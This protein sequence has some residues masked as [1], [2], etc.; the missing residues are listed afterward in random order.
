MRKERFAKVVISAEFK[1]DHPVWAISA[2]REHD[3]RNPVPICSQ[4]LQRRQSID[5]RHHDVQHNDI[6][7]FSL[8]ST[9][10]RRGI[11]KD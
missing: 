4:F 2:R 9:T 10:E 1:A 6:R 5:S 8:Q 11:V 3:D 7:T